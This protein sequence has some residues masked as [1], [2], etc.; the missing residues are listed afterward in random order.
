MIA[1]SC[2]AS[3]SLAVHCSLQLNENPV[4]GQRLIRQNLCSAA[5]LLLTCHLFV[6]S[7]AGAK[8][9]CFH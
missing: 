8:V 9:N 3:L 2:T 4:R 6:G 5:D 7:V 1:T